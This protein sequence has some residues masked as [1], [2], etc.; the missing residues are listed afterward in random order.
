MH[1]NATT[2]ARPSAPVET[3]TDMPESWHGASV[4]ITAVYLNRDFTNATEQRTKAART[5]SIVRR[6]LLVS[7]FQGPLSNGGPEHS[8]LVGGKAAKD[9]KV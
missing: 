5:T 1:K 9:D 3:T 6:I 2:D 4:I 7:Y 8:R